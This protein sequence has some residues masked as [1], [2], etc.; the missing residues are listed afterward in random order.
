VLDVRSDPEYLPVD[1][2]AVSEYALPIRLDSRILGV[3]N[4]ESA[5]PD[6]FGADHVAV[7]RTFA[8]QLAGAIH[9]AAVNRE[10][11]ETNAAL[12]RANRR[13]AR[14]SVR[15]PL[16]GLANRRRFDEVL[17][18]EWRRATRVSTPLGLL[19]VD[20]DRFK[21]YNDHLGHRKGDDCLRS[22]ASS[23]RRSVRRAGELVARYGGEEFAVLLPGASE[24]EAAETAERVRAGVA[25]LGI[26]HPAPV[27]GPV[28]TVSVGAATARPLPGSEPGA[29]IDAADGALYRAKAE[30]RDRVRTV[31]VPPA[32]EPATP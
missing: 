10:L 18:R 20:I 17:D 5:S 19:M 15:D 1:P 22:V 8:D 32:K 25:G 31:T 7:F 28:V 12:R 3:L 27:A 24:D 2:A 16:T 14:L 11:E 26:P 13:L 4:L 21:A 6:A 30:G 9:L 23:L 29:L